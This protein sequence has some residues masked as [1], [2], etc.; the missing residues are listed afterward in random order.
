MRFAKCSLDAADQ[1]PFGISHLNVK[2]LFAK[3]FGLPHEVGLDAACQRLGIEMEGTHHRGDDDAWNIADV[4]CRL[5][6]ANRS[7]GQPGLSLEH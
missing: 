4:L 1:Y 3:S 5:L 6:A 7:V 2:T